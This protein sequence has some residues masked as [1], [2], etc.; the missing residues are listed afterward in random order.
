M[1]TGAA[2]TEDASQP[3]GVGGAPVEAGL[4]PLLAVEVEDGGDDAEDVGLL[5]GVGG[6]V[7]D[8]EVLDEALVDLSRV[9]RGGGVELALRLL[10]QLLAELDLLFEG[11]DD[12]GLF[13]ELFTQSRGGGQPGVGLLQLRV[14]SLEVLVELG[15]DFAFSLKPENVGILKL[16]HRYLSLAFYSQWQS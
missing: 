5:A 1:A 14:E 12:L 16:L 8:D 9:V 11:R 2:G 10:E 4:L 13:V 6:D 3:G 7:A 15:L